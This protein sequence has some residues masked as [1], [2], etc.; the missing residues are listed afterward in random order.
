MGRA[1]AQAF[2]FA[3]EAARFSATPSVPSPEL[4]RAR[5]LV[6]SLEVL[7]GPAYKA[8][9]VQQAEEQVRRYEGAVAT[10]SVH[11]TALARHLRHGKAIEELFSRGRW[12]PTDSLAAGRPLVVQGSG[13]LGVSGR[14]GWDQ[15]PDMVSMTSILIESPW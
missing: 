15:F 7:G 6:E 5:A 8:G 9:L 1:E 4:E 2:H 12:S 13:P 10:A 3:A 11:Q 14:Y